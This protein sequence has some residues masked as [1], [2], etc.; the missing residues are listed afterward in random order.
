MAPLHI[1]R[2]V[3]PHG[4]GP[5]GTRQVHCLLQVKTNGLRVDNGDSVLCEGPND[6]DDIYFLHA[7]LAHAS[8]S[9]IGVEHPVGP[10][11]LAG[12]E[13]TWR[14]IEPRTRDASHGIG[15]A[16]TRRDQSDTEISG[17]FRIVLGGDRA[18]LLVRVTNC[19]DGIA[20]RERIVQVHC[21][22]AGDQKNVANTLTGYEADNVIG[23]LWPVGHV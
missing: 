13:E 5:S 6:G 11:D 17:G 18:S 14:R 1:E 20:V 15:T 19:L 16:W 8:G 3:H 9:S 10:F 12:D 4:S 21:A 7:E 23:K 2:N 22:A